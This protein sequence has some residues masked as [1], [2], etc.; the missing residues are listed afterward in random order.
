MESI[1]RCDRT[2]YAAQY[3][4]DFTDGIKTEVEIL[5]FAHDPMDAADRVRGI[6]ELLA[7][8]RSIVGWTFDEIREVASDDEMHRALTN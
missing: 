8:D 4:I 2:L 7:T 1:P 3:A 6:N 5:F